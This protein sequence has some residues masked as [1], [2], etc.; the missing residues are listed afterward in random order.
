MGRVSYW[1]PSDTVTDVFDTV[2]DFMNVYDFAGDDRG[3]AR[4][5]H[6]RKSILS[7]FSRVLCHAISKEFGRNGTIFL[8]QGAPGAGKTALLYKCGE[9]AQA[10]SDEVG[11]Q[12]WSVIEIDKF[13]LYSPASLM[14]QAGQIY[15]SSETTE[16]S[17]EVKPKAFGYELGGYARKKTRQ[18]PDAGMR[19]SLEE[20]AE[21]RPLLLLLDEAQNL[22]GY[23][24]PLDT[25][26]LGQTLDHI[27]NGRF[28]YPVVLLCG[29][30]GNS[31][32]AFMRL[33][34][35]R[36][37]GKCLI[38]LG[39]LP[40]A[41]AQAVIRDWLVKEGDAQEADIQPWIDAIARETHGWPQHIMA[42]AQPAATLLKTQNGKATPEALE[43]ILKEGREEKYIYYNSRIKALDGSGL[44]VLA[45]LLQQA[46]VSSSL[47]LR[48][49]TLLKKLVETG[50][51]PQEAAERFFDSALHRGVLSNAGTKT[52]LHYDV[53]IP[54]M[55]AFLVEGFGSHT[56]SNG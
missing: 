35:S 34:I 24:D 12:K 37:R 44:D 55:K 40:E 13:A 15:K 26:I 47:N 18:L 33:G 10:G 7:N 50:P 45:D 36:F 27:L 32:E 48:R 30:L 19:R 14:E 4:H 38:N 8:I 21:K 54:S 20:L 31:E 51:M 11:G 49:K 25:E 56:E 5:F 1:R 9:L 29:G 52:S 6:G 23:R 43:A 28:E 2:S 16:N 3:E 46:P 42:Y 41:D 22:D 53:P 39:R 17:F